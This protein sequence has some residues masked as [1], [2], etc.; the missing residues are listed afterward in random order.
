[1]SKA[2]TK[3]SNGADSEVEEADGLRPLMPKIM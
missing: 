1:M 3:E 2:F